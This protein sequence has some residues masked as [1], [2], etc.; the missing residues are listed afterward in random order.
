MIRAVSD[1]DVEMVRAFARDRWG[2]DVAVSQGRIHQLDQ[3]PGFV[4]L[5]PD[6][7][8][9]GLVTYLIEGD[10]CE[11]VSIDAVDQGQGTGT[12][13]L[14]R[15]VEAARS[16]GCRQVRLVTTN[17]NLR[18]LRFYQ[19]RGFRLIGLNPG[20]VEHSRRLKPQIPAI[21][22]HGIPLRDELLLGLDL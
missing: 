9:A 15:A 16:A 14:A 13:L 18:A 2:A 5:T 10:S 22:A 3:L 19:R 17:D 8:V 1:A 7:R 11:V 6:G 20:A 4:A 12:A 21:G